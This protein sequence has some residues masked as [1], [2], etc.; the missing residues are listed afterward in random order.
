MGDTHPYRVLAARGLPVASEYHELERKFDVTPDLA[1]SGLEEL[2]E[3]RSV[4]PSQDIQLD[5]DYYDTSGRSLLA[6]GITLRRNR[7][8]GNTGWT[9]E[10]PAGRHD[11]RQFT[12]VSTSTEIPAELVD[13]ARAWIRDHDVA[14][15]ANIRTH[16]TTCWLLGADDQVLARINDDSVIAGAEGPPGGILVG[17]REWEVE[18][19]EGSDRLLRAT[20]R[21]MLDLGAIPARSATLSRALGERRAASGATAALSAATP[22]GPVLQSYLREQ[23]QALLGCDHGVR[24]DQ[25]DAVHRMRVAS[26]RLRT[27]LS[28]FGLLVDRSLTDPIREELQELAT[29]L[30]LARDAEVQQA[31]FDH[32]IQA[33][34]AELTMGPIQ[35]WINQDLQTQYA[36]GHAEALRAVSSKRYF[37]L[38]DQLDALAAA[39]PFTEIAAL[40]AG[41]VLT[42]PVRRAYEKLAADVSGARAAATEAERDELLHDA[43]KL[44]KRLR[45]AAEAVAPAFGHPATK[46]AEAAGSVQEILGEHQDSVVARQVLTEMA[47]RAYLEG[48]NTFSFGRLHAHEQI[49]AEQAERKF[50]AVWDKGSAEKLR[51]WLR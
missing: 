23:V 31:R 25:H 6:A 14:L 22:A 2:P 3:V 37:R 38:L 5:M 13:Q 30:G 27:A 49:R 35:E 45:Y 26:R 7:G 15:V 8:D 33:E 9:L 10:I 41:K 42:K 36:H 18:L 50:G 34:P 39:P 47:A 19:A 44:A 4:S 51:R 17:W 21:R 20:R 46:L 32:A 40:P 29:I 48:Q 16:R 43:R 12:A 24:N 28:T 11:R 1:L